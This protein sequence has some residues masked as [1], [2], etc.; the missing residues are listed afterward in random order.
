MGAAELAAHSLVAKPKPR[1]CARCEKPL[2]KDR[3]AKRKQK[4]YLCE[5]QAKREQK[6]RAHD[7]RVETLYGLRPGEYQQLYKAQGGKCAI[8]GCQA[9]GLRIS[10]AVDHDHKK[11]LANREAVRGLLCKRHNKMIGYERDN[12]EVF[13]SIAGYLRFP[14]AQAILTGSPSR[15]SVSDDS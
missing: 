2:S 1:V 9:R 3:L 12:P 4:C 14:P 8:H 10:L 7:R 11:G 5:V 15:G 13:E 6:Q